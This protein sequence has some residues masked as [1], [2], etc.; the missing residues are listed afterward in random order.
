LQKSK[1]P[2]QNYSWLLLRSI[3]SQTKQQKFK[4]LLPQPQAI[5]IK[6]KLKNGTELILIVSTPQQKRAM[7]S[8]RQMKTRTHTTKVESA[9]QCEC[10]EKYAGTGILPPQTNK[11]VMQ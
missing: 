7:N 9:K 10:Y 3:K 2:W 1:E 6:S 5:Q 11:E 8:I 4:T